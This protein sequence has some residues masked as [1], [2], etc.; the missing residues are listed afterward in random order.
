M[1]QL[2]K[3]HISPANKPATVNDYVVSKWHS[4]DSKPLFTT[5]DLRDLVT[6]IS[7]AVESILDVSQKIQGPNYAITGA[8]GTG[9]TWLLQNMNELLNK[10]FEELGT[11]AQSSTLT[12][13]PR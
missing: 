7:D 2:S 12:W 13:L 9:K 4:L 10:Y 3:L 1:E 11:K 8:R 5:P 6:G